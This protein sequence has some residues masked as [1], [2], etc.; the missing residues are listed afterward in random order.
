MPI[1][2]K[3]CQVS[4]TVSNI[5]TSF[6][7]RP[8][9]L[10]SHPPNTSMRFG[11][12]ITAAW[13]ALALGMAPEHWGLDQKPVLRDRMWTS[14][15]HWEVLLMPPNTMRESEVSHTAVCPCLGLGGTCAAAVLM[16]NVEN[17]IFFAAFSAHDEAV[18]HNPCLSRLLCPGRC[19]KVVLVQYAYL[20]A[21]TTVHCKTI[22]K[23][24]ADKCPPPPPLT[25]CST[26]L[27]STVLMCKLYL[28]QL[29]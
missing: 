2:F 6:M 1:T 18:C 12:H 3:Q 20:P 26:A 13:L 28:P 7:K 21:S 4:V 9:A 15:R 14:A 23:C 24:Y 8:A 10:G 27:H 11:P 29:P 17:N 5:K 22:A 16:Q 25:W 19:C